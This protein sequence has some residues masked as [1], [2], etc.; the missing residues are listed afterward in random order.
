MRPLL[1]LLSTAAR[2][3]ASSG[4]RS[5]LIHS[6][7]EYEDELDGF[8][9]FPGIVRGSTRFGVLLAGTA[10]G[11]LPGTW[12]GMVHYSLPWVMPGVD[13]DITG[14]TWY[15]RHSDGSL[16]GHIAGGKL[17]RDET[18]RYAEVVLRVEITE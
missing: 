10:H 18:G 15:F 12:A 2:V 14:G 9:L 3:M 6:E 8:A 7:G 1:L 17:I 4:G 5:F 11:D 13:H 16:H